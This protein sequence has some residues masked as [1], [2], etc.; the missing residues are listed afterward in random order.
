MCC[1]NIGDLR[2]ENGESAY[3][4]FTE[5]PHVGIHS[6]LAHLSPVWQELCLEK[7]LTKEIFRSSLF[8]LL[9]KAVN[10]AHFIVAGVNERESS[11]STLALLHISL[12]NRRRI[13]WFNGRPF[14]SNGEGFKSFFSCLDDVS[15]DVPPVTNHSPKSP[16]STVEIPPKF[17]SLAGAQDAGLPQI[18]F[19]FNIFVFA[20]AIWIINVTDR[21]GFYISHF[22]LLK[23]SI[24]IQKLLLQVIFV[25]CYLFFT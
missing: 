4:V 9:R 20:W 23:M 15:V 13:I 3:Q 16:P 11:S 25:Y 5:E 18:F 14:W 1:V 8:E 24:I 17:Y 19:H 12:K 6:L 10:N 21:Y 22:S 2:S 7:T